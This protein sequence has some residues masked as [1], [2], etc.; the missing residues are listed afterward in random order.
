MDKFTSILNKLIS[1]L[2]IFFIVFL[3]LNKY[4]IIHFSDTLKN[5]LS[6]LT[7]ILILISST[8]EV[9]TNKSGFSKF[10][11][12]TILFCSIVGG[13]FAIINNQLNLFVY[14]CIIFSLAYGVIDLVYKKA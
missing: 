9:I 3:I 8:R 10:I 2:I 14:I 5:V 13:V 11:N 4:Y 12:C 6:F 7:I 1:I